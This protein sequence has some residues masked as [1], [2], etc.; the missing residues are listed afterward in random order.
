M[1]RLRGVP[2][3]ADL[4]IIT[5]TGS[6]EEQ[7]MRAAARFRDMLQ[8]YLQRKPY[9]DEHTQLLG[10]APAA[11]AKINYTWRYRLTLSAKNSRRLRQLISFCLCEFAKDKQNRG[12]NAFADVNSYD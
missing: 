3:F 4:F 12:V 11:I 9:C 1:R 6:F 7:V 2:P 5:F 10:P 8:A